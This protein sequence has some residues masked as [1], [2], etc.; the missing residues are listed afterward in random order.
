M[1]YYD[2]KNRLLQQESL[3]S[4]QKQ[5]TFR[6]SCVSRVTVYKWYVEFNLKRNHFEDELRAGRPRSA[7]T[8]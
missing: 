5:K 3:E 7:L 6:D 1:I 8:P 2:Y 4:L